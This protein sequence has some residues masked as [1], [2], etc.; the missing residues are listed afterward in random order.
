[1]HYHVS[2]GGQTYGPYTLA[3][4]ERYVGSG[5]ILLTDLAKS[6]EMADW[7]P[8]GQI[9]NPAPPQ[10]ETPQ[11]TGAYVPP[12]Q[13]TQPGFGQPGVNQPGFGQPHYGAQIPDTAPVYG[14]TSL[15][16]DPPNLHWALVMIFDVLTCGL[17]QSIWNLIIAAWLRRVQPN[18]NALFYYIGG[19][20]LLLIYGGSASPIFLGAMHHHVMHMHSGLYL[21][22]LI[23]W[24][25]R[26][27]A[28]FNV[29]TSLEE[30]YN[31]PEPIGYHMNPVLLFFFG[32][33]Y[34]QAELNRINQIRQAIRY[35]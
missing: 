5:H 2:R 30:H 28:R 14:Q 6:D 19:Y 16:P 21:L 25:L 13:Y 22:W 10:A 12:Q 33:I 11:P 7:L 32:G 18:S 9:L 31:G 29:K 20:V 26:L 1:M 15:Y 24:V 35:R 8:V 4:L 23:A 3:D 17:F 27:L 34:I